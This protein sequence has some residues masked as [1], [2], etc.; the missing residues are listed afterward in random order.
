MDSGV[1]LRP[2]R[3][4][5]LPDIAG[6]I[7]QAM[8]ED[9][10]YTW[11]CPGRYEH[12]ADFRNAFLRRLKK[13]FVT[14]GYVMVVAVENSGNGEKICGYSVWERLGTGTNAERWQ[15]EN[16]GWWHGSDTPF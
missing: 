5:D 9:E 16:N 2:A 13:R 14:V 7:A 15:S 6:L 4:Q 12:Y 10:L 1:R 3:A 8:L 11:L